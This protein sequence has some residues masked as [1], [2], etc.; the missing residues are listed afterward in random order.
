MLPMRAVCPR[1]GKRRGEPAA[2]RCPL[3]LKRRARS[4]SPGRGHRQRGEAGRGHRCADDGC[5]GHAQ[6]RG[7][8]VVAAH[9]VNLEVMM[10][11]DP[12]A[13]EPRGDRREGNGREAA[14]AAEGVEADRG[15]A[16]EVRVPR[17]HVGAVPAEEHRH[18]GERLRSRD[19]RARQGEHRREDD[20]HLL[21]LQPALPVQDLPGAGAEGDAEQGDCE[22]GRADGLGEDAGSGAT[23]AVRWDDV[24]RNLQAAN[25]GRQRKQ[26]RDVGHALQVIQQARATSG[27]WPAVVVSAPGPRA[28]LLEDVAVGRAVAEELPNHGGDHDDAED[29]ADPEVPDDREDPPPLP[30]QALARLPRQVCIGRGQR[31]EVGI[32]CLHEVQ[33]LLNRHLQ[34]Q[35]QAAAGAGPPA[36][37]ALVPL[38]VGAP[39]VLQAL[40]GRAAE[41]RVEPE[42][43]A[44]LQCPHPEE[45]EQDERVNN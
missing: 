1:R 38:G 34:G 6:V 28:G 4:P 30:P 7:S 18:P 21:E 22:P 20:G 32:D 29:A 2:S 33:E 13:A 44:P 26:A 10:P 15:V 19:K 37:S 41:P 31:V 11:A 36:P 14:E 40:R 9:P 45:L 27:V 3:A 39:P 5:S 17:L 43:E 16:P 12:D 23:A 35:E 24:L 25:H 8:G 42:H